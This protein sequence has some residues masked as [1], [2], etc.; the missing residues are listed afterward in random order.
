VSGYLR[1][2]VT[3]AM[4]PKRAIHPVV[5]SVHAVPRSSA[6]VASVTL[7][8]IAESA[9]PGESHHAVRAHVDDV[10]ASLLAQSSGQT[11]SSR[12]EDELAVGDRPRNRDPRS[13]S[14]SSVHEPRE[15]SIRRDLESDS[16]TSVRLSLRERKATSSESIEITKF[17]DTPLVPT[18]ASG[19]DVGDPLAS[20][21]IHPSTVPAPGQLRPH[22]SASRSPARPAQLADAGQKPDEIQIHIGRIEVTAVP[23]PAPARP[24]AKPERRS[25]NLNEYL[26]QRRGGN[27]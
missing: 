18:W 10:E 11:G 8:E 20:G 2:L 1:R 14:G 24:A 26:K 13:T 17:V 4:R 12:V 27:R 16:E 25:V 7:E 3:S 5:G 15:I 19:R 6:E 23:P 22:A 21:A 9:W